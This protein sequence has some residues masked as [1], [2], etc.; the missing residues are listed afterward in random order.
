MQQINSGNITGQ[1][2]TTGF[3]EI[4]TAPPPASEGREYSLVV[5]FSGLSAD[6][7]LIFREA[8]AVTIDSDPFRNGQ[9]SNVAYV[10][11]VINSADAAHVVSVKDTSGHCTSV[12][13]TWVL[14]DTTAGIGSDGTWNQNEKQELL[15]TVQRINRT[16]FF[17]LL[18]QLGIV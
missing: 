18:N 15:S 10:D 9:T 12:N 5:V 13:V 17:D 6:H 16:T 3:V 11:F 1:N 8:G 2:L 4:V 14:Y 7:A